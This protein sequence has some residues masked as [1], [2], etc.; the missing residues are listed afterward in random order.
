[1]RTLHTCCG[2]R[3]ATIQHPGWGGNSI[4]FMPFPAASCATKVQKAP[5]DNQP[6]P[7]NDI[8]PLR[9]TGLVR[10]VW[11]TIAKYRSFAEFCRQR[12]AA[13]KDSHEQRIFESMAADW[14]K[15]ADAYEGLMRRMPPER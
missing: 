12:A 13:T 2:S 1:M 9:E 8:A 15:I 3:G 11:E 14:L 6:S 10:C 4:E 5:G 7:S